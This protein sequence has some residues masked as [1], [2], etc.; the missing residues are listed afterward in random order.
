VVIHSFCTEGVIGS[1]SAAELQFTLSTLRKGPRG[2]GA[3]E[4]LALSGVVDI[5]APLVGAI[6]AD[7]L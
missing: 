6:T 1:L 5:E 4:A 7:Y 2:F 3:A